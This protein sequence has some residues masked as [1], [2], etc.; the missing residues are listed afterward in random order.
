MSLWNSSCACVVQCVM[1]FYSS[2]GPRPKSDPS[3]PW[4]AL[5]FD[6]TYNHFRGAVTNV[7]VIDGKVHQ[8][9]KISSAHNS[10][11]YEVQEVGIMS[12]DYQSTQE[13]LVHYTTCSK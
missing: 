13:L 12:P 5:L 8:G 2:H 4:K 1:L 6:S 7:A 3:K 9:D 11:V 10:K